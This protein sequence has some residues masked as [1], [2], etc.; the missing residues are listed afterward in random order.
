MTYHLYRHFDE[1]GRLL[2]VGQSINALK[3]LVEHKQQSNWFLSIAKVEIKQFP[4][5][6]DAF[7]A[8]QQ[9]ILEENPVF[10]L[11][12][13]NPKKRNIY[14]PRPFK[15]LAQKIDDYA[16]QQRGASERRQ[17]A[18]DMADA[19]KTYQEIGDEYGVTRQ[20]AQF[21]VAKAR[22]EMPKKVS[23]RG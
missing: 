10:N 13:P 6:K 8:E 1:N 7:E 23:K 2:Y 18:R 11:C 20:R 4:T 19:G 22:L 12:R 15:T 9:A 5:K 14:K 21:M 17:A 3:R 16:I